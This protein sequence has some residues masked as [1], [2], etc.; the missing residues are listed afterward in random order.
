MDTVLIM[1]G[2]ALR[3]AFEA[4]VLPGFERAS[5]LRT[6]VRWDPT[7]L[8]MKDIAA[9]ERADVVVLTEEAIGQLA[10]QGVVERDS[11]VLV[12]RAVLGLAV[13]KGE[14]KP[15]ISTTPAFKRALLGA[16]SVAYSQ[17]GASGI[18]FDRLIERL[19][20]AEGVRSRATIIPAGLTAERLVTGEADLAVQQISELVVV[21]GV[22][23]VG[24]FPPEC[25]SATTFRAAI[26]RDGRNRDGA[27]RL[28]AALATGDAK[29]A[30]R[31]A[32]LVTDD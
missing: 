6:H 15:D 16:R 10:A 30:Y 13:R 28:V 5:G 3:G 24:P 19:E 7:T 14:A 26:F 22:E 32:G 11:S 4:T 20:I 9:G 31:A 12:A 17:A 21:P 8:L 18:Y 1:S 25:Q 2:I 27:K 23:V 29:A